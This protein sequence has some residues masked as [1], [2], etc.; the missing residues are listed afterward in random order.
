MKQQQ[1][2]PNDQ[3]QSS[4]QKEALIFP[5][6]FN[7]KAVVDNTLSTT[8]TIQFIDKLFLRLAVANE[9]LGFKESSKGNFVSHT[10][11]VLLLDQDHM[12]EV[13]KELKTVPGLKFA[14]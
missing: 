9:Y 12:N 4:D 8:E 1:G 6:S 11:R 3:K 13:Y 14:I 10:F 5:L 2:G 7:L